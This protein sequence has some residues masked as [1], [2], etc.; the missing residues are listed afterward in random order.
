M[1]GLGY[2]ETTSQAKGFKDVLKP[3]LHRRDVNL[4]S[5]DNEGRIPIF[6]MGQ[7]AHRL[8]LT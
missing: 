8:A 7:A 3:P 4:D 2:C 1:D 6:S 5:P